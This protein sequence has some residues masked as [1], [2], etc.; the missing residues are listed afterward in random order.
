MTEEEQYLE[1]YE[2]AWLEEEGELEQPKETEAVEADEHTEEEVVE[3][4]NEETITDEDQQVEESENVEEQTED[5]LTSFIKWNGKEIPVTD[6]EKTA[7]AQKGFDA[8]KKWQEAAKIRPFKDVIDSNGLTLEQIQTLADIVKGKNPEAIALLAKQAGIDLYDAEVK[9][10]TPTVES[11]NYELDDVIAEIN[12]DEAIATEMNS[13]VSSVP[14]SVKDRFIKEPKILRGLNVDMR[15]GI[16]QVIMPEVIK[17][18]A[19]NP[20][21]D[22]VETYQ[23]VGRVLLSKQET[24]AKVEPKP[25][26]TVDDKRKVAVSKKVSAPT[27]SVVDDYDA[28]WDDNSHFQSVLNRLNGF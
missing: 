1:E 21:R 3:D 16:A 5:K 27:K 23:E 13:Y 10:Y 25:Q 4:S 17:Q 9:S 7:L 11:R 24:V 26:P 2:K 14:Q 15:Q 22:F 28:A 6:E 12:Q 19:I 20:S 8:E 18:L